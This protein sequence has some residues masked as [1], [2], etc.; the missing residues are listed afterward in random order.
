MTPGEVRAIIL[1]IAERHDGTFEVITWQRLG[2][3]TSAQA[4]DEALAAA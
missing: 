1:R 4:E 2:E 3:T